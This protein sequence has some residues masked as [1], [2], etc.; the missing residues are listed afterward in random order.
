MLMHQMRKSL[1]ENNK[2]I[3]V[4]QEEKKKGFFARLFGKKEG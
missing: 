4:A 2:L 3:A 1:E